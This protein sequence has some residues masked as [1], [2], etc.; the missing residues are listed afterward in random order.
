MTALCPVCKSK[1]PYY[2]EAGDFNQEISA[3][4][5]RYYR[6]PS[7]KLVFLSPVPDNLGSFYR[8]TYP[9]YQMPS[10]QELDAMAAQ[11]RYKLDIV[12]KFSR[13]G[14]LLEIGPSYGA[15]AYLAKKAGFE[16][17]AIEMDP[18]CCQYL[19]DTVGIKAINTNDVD[20]S[21]R[22]LGPYDVIA[23]WHVIEHL[24]NPLKTLE[25][26]SGKLRQGGI[27][28]I[29]SPNPDALQFRIFGRYW[30][31]VDAPRHLRLIPM[32]TLAEQLK[33]F[34]LQIV[35][36][37]STGK[38]SRIFHVIG[39]WGTSFRNII[40]AS[41]MTLQSASPDLHHGFL[42]RFFIQSSLFFS[43]GYRLLLFLL[44]KPFER[45]KGLG[46]AYTVVA[47]K[48]EGRTGHGDSR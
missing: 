23:L 40:K 11:E 20:A 9:A 17:E 13:K 34:G 7:C 1:S 38:A 43:V 39:W 22:T 28:V 42:N 8:E 35:L 30:T 46:V 6:C 33:M 29:A 26:I 47:R 18:R 36:T 45:I 25:T 44:L 48:T 14:R 16:V 4:V 24:P 19:S 32:T 2:F 15:F 31:H 41:R 37:T 21:L 3:E 5:F 27:L 12:Q 10:L